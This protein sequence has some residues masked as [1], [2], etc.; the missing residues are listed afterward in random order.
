MV[1]CRDIEGN[2][3][4]TIMM[5]SKI[6]IKDNLKVSHYKNGDLIPYVQ[7]NVQ[8]ENLT[9]GAWWK[10]RLKSPHLTA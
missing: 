2:V 5:C 9:S 6:W 1:Q 7:D 10:F 8:W 3:Y 4:D